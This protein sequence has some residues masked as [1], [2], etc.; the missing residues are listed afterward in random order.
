LEI[1]VEDVH[2]S[3]FYHQ[4]PEIGSRAYYD[5]IDL[6]ELQKHCGL[7][8]S[9]IQGYYWM[10]SP[11]DVKLT[12]YVNDL[13]NQR[14]TAS[15]PEDSKMFKFILNHSFGRLMYHGF[16]TLKSKPF[17]DSLELQKYVKR[18]GRRLVQLDLKTK[19]ARIMRTYD[20]G[21]NFC[22]VGAMIL[23]TARRIV[24]DYFE[25]FKSLGIP[26]FLHNTDSFMIPTVDVGKIAH[27]IGPQLGLLKL[28]QS[29]DEAIILRASQYYMS[30]SYFR[31]TGKPKTEI[32]AQ[33]SIRQFYVDRL[34]SID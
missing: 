11:N 30:D 5:K 2:S 28:E 13:Y 12:D 8:Y 27:L 16:D 7:K 3:P 9:I 1:V 24:N 17:T 18:Y 20:K 14:L 23:S 34:H 19:T 15:T 33:P 22:Y 32:Q 31:F 6:E 26:V 10:K 25:L 4:L 21:F 29:S